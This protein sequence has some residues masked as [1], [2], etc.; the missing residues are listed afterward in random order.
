MQKANLKLVEVVD[1]KQYPV[2][3]MSCDVTLKAKDGEKV[4]FYKAKILT[5]PSLNKTE[6][7]KFKLVGD[8][9]VYSAKSNF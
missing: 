3:G 2:E 8:A 1:E 5:R 6:L 4:N 7:A 9:P